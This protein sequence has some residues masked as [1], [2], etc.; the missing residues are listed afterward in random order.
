MAKSIKC[1]VGEILVAQGAQNLTIGELSNLVK[2][3]YQGK[4]Q[5]I[6]AEISNILNGL[7]KAKNMNY[8]DSKRQNKSELIV[9]E[10][11]GI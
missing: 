2:A 9:G 8:F 6:D 3:Q 5:K 1:I 10:Y 11:V 7:K 4:A